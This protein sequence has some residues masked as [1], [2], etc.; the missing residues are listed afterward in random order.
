MLLRQKIADY[1]ENIET[2][3][4]KAINVT[5]ALLVL[6][7]SIIFVAETYPISIEIRNALDTIDSIILGIFAAEYLLRFWCAEAKFKYVFSLYS[8]IDLL[9]ILPFFVGTVDITFIRVFRWFRILR[10][11]RFMG[12]KTLIGY[13]S[14]EDSSILIRIAFTL[15]SIIFVY[16]G[17]IYQTEHLI[18]P[19]A[20]ATFLD[21]VYFSVA[22]MTTVGFGDIAPISELGRFLTV[23][24]ILTGIALIPWQVGDVIKRLV[25]TANQIEIPCSSC[26][27]AL[28]DADAYFCKNCGAKLRA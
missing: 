14:S 3:I 5:I 25:K 10:L 7:S 8:A 9:A 6:L 16:S 12:G 19:T 17:L 11:I 2:P 23:L 26:H 13:V 1:L 28:H 4:G 18:N 21:A 27:L 20:F 22:T 15:F 24:M